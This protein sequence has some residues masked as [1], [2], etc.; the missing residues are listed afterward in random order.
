MIAPRCLALAALL[1][2][3]ACA[4]DPPMRADHAAPAYRA[5]LKACRASGSRQANLVV[6]RR[7][8]IWVAYPFTYP[9]EARRQIRACMEAKGYKPAG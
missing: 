6:S 9:P 8:P 7:F 4:Y 3:A 5:D 2:L 1:G